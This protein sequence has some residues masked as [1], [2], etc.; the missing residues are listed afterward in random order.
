MGL[1]ESA[2]NKMEED[3]LCGSYGILAKAGKVQVENPRERAIQARK[4]H[5]VGIAGRGQLG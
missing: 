3:I 4:T 2:A 5:A 1:T